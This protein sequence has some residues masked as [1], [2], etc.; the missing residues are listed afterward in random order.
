MA[1]GI[2]F[3]NGMA[4]IADNSTLI[5]AD[6]YRHQLVGFDVAADGGLSGRRVWGWLA[7]N[8]RIQCVPTQWNPGS[9]AL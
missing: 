5:V 2:A 4:V 9:S 1:D 6:S 3:P 7:M 8:P